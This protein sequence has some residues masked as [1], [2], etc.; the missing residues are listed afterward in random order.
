MLV[1]GFIKG[2]APVFKRSLQLLS[3]KR[4]ALGNLCI[5]SSFVLDQNKSS[6]ET[7]LSPLKN[8]DIVLLW[9]STKVPPPPPRVLNLLQPT[10]DFS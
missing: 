4:R 3:K 5:E 6:S 2:L 1:A 7:K 9:L 10:D 8:D